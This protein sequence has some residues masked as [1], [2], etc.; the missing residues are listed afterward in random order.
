M[1]RRPGSGHSINCRW[2]TLAQGPIEKYIFARES[3]VTL[4]SLLACPASLGRLDQDR[5]TFNILESWHESKPVEHDL[6]GVTETWVSVQEDR[7][8]DALG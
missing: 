2:Y 3:E 8:L 1:P 7:F 4:E 5:R 6:E